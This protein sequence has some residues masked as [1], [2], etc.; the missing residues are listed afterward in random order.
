MNHQFILDENQDPIFAIIPYCEYTKLFI[1]A[2]QVGE[3]ELSQEIPLTIRLPN[4]GAGA[5]IDL[6]R[7]VDYWVRNGI[8]S[9]PIN[10]RAKAFKEFTGREKFTVEALVR[11]CFVPESYRNTMQ[12]VGE[13]TSQIV[14]TGLFREVKFDCAQFKEGY[15][16]VRSQALI[17][18]ED[19]VINTERYSRAVKCL[20]IV[21]NK[22]V[23]FC[24]AHPIQPAERIQSD[25]VNRIPKA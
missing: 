15:P 10:Q 25:W 11:A 17:N 8:L 16:F 20:E 7:F 2:V 1:P 23:D 24:K 21:E 18:D 3:A 22:A 19:K 13:V 12:M 14:A 5:A 6:P 4:A 9:M